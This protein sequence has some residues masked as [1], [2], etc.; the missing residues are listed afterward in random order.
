MSHFAYKVITCIE[1][2]SETSGQTNSREEGLHALI[3][4]SYC[5][6]VDQIPVQDLLIPEVERVWR[7]LL[8]QCLSVRNSTMSKTNKLTVCIQQSCLC[9]GNP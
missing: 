7:M 5:G 6:Q 9:F 3:R 8:L 4:I 1:D 2:A